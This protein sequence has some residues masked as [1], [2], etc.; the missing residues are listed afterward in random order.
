MKRVVVVCYAISR[1]KTASCVNR[2]GVSQRQQRQASHRGHAMPDSLRFTR[3]GSQYQVSVGGRSVVASYVEFI[4]DVRT[5]LYA[6]CGSNRRAACW[7]PLAVGA[8]LLVGVRVVY[9]IT[10]R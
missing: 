1:K 3:S 4:L 10:G 6:Y 8:A 2:D 5:L 9:M 7:R